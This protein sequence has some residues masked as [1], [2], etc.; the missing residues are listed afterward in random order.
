M[1][2]LDWMTCHWMVGAAAL[3][4]ISATA[5]P[6]NATTTTDNLRHL[7]LRPAASSPILFAKLRCLLAFRRSGFALEKFDDYPTFFRMTVSSIWLR[8]EFIKVLRPLRNTSSLRTMAIRP[9]SLNVSNPTSGS[10]VKKKVLGYRHGRCEFLTTFKRKAIL[11][12]STTG[13]IPIFNY[14][15]M[16]KVFLDLHNQDQRL[17]HS[18]LSPS[19]FQCRIELQQ[20]TS[21]SLQ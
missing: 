8:Q 10:N 16:V 20:H 18:R 19:L 5:A 13:N 11:N 2:L 7:R 15:S 6:I 3:L 21:F 17:L 1:K 9:I 12:P 14:V 4:V